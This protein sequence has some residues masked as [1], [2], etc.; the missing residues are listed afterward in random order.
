LNLKPWLTELRIQMIQSKLE[1][2]S[3]WLEQIARQTGGLVKDNMLTMDTPVLRGYIRRFPV[4]EGF[5][6]TVT[7][8]LAFQDVPFYQ[9]ATASNYLL[10]K[11][12]LPNFQFDTISGKGLDRLAIHLPGILASNSRLEAFSVIRAGKPFKMLTLL[13]SADWIRRHHQD[14][15]FLLNERLLDK[16]VMLF[17]QASPAILQHALNFFAAMDSKYLNIE[18]KTTAYD[19]L[20]KVLP[21]FDH[22]QASSFKS[23]KNQQDGEILLQVRD[24]LL[25]GMEDG[26]LTIETL[27]RE[28][29]MSP[30]KLKTLF[31]SV[32]GLPVYQYFLRERLAYA[33]RLIESGTC[34]VS[35]A[36]FRVGYHN[37]SKFSA[38]FKK[39]FGITPKETPQSDWSNK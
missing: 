26:C 31:H 2:P 33:R 6:M 37:I 39:E 20:S 38:A 17:E 35:Q 1:D 10:L 30:T 5:T 32:F 34:N 24:R 12:Y 28:F 22:R 36:G 29:G 27:S 23:L 13:L 3:A 18:A 7:D 21:L 9:T 15:A 11:L 16:P 14:G 25:A 19:I 8:L 4:E